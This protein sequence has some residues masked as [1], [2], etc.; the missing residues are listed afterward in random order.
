MQDNEV[1]AIAVGET[2]FAFRVNGVTIA[3]RHLAKT[4]GKGQRI[5]E[6]ILAKYLVIVPFLATAF[7]LSDD[8]SESVR[9]GAIKAKRLYEALH[10][11]EENTMPFMMVFLQ[12]A[13]MG[14]GPSEAVSNLSQDMRQS[15]FYD[16]FPQGQRQSPAKRTLH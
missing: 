5:D 6:K 14:S 3:K 7:R 9:Y 13:E 1:M 4:L 15:G 10:L 11:N 12:L 8:S 16:H 2:R